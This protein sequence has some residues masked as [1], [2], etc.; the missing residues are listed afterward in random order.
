MGRFSRFKATFKAAFEQARNEAKTNPKPKTGYTHKGAYTQKGKGFTLTYYNADGSV[1]TAAQLRK[2][3]QEHERQQAEYEAAQRKLKET[4]SKMG[5]AVSLVSDEA[6]ISD[7]HDIANSY[8]KARVRSNAK[9][10]RIVLDWRPLTKSGKVPK[11]VL[12]TSVVWDR[13]NGDS[14]IVHVGYLADIEPYTADV[15]I[16]TSG[17]LDSYKIRVK[18][19]VMRVVDE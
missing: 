8:C 19:G 4:Y 18:D 16:W 3:E 5:V 7:A 11:C 6:I 17:Q 10:S 2:I 12:K 15:H 9:P 14:V 1:M 13:A